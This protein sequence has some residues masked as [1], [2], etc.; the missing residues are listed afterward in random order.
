MDSMNNT[1]IFNKENLIDEELLLLDQ[2]KIKDNL[3]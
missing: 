1:R 2:N 3:P